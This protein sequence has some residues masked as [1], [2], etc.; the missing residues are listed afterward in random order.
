MT[1]QDKMGGHAALVVK[2]LITKSLS[3][4]IITVGLKT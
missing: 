2:H 1:R 3:D 4:V